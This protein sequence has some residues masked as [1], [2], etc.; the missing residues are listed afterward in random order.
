MS[1]EINMFHVDNENYA[2]CKC[3]A[4][5]YNNKRPLFSTTAEGRAYAPEMLAF[6]PYIAPPRQTLATMRFT[7][8]PTFLHR[9]AVPFP[10]AFLNASSGSLTMLVSNPV[11]YAVNFLRAESLGRVQKTVGLC[12][13]FFKSTDDTSCSLNALA[14]PVQHTLGSDISLLCPG[15]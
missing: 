15:H 2:E 12:F 4:A 9:K 8:S 10:F 7:P 1:K 3:Y 6:L 14:S 11:N 13:P 5:L